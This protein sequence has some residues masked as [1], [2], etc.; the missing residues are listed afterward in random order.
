MPDINIAKGIDCL[1]RVVMGPLA[2][3]VGDPDE[4]INRSYAFPVR[5]VEA[6]VV[7]VIKDSR[8]DISAEELKE[9]IS[10]MN[11]GGNTGQQPE[12]GGTEEKK[13]KGPRVRMIPMR[14][15]LVNGITIVSEVIRK[16]PTV[17]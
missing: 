15:R 11:L 16:V 2:I 3:R 7:Q 4:E 1:T 12:S 6:F 17:D 8:P 13:E 14:S 9:K 5:Q 10:A